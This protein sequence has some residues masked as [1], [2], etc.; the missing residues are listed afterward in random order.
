MNMTLMQHF[1]ELRRRV[2]WCVLIFILTFIVGWQI[3][4]IIQNFLTQPLLNVWDTGS[5]LYSG[6]TDGL[7]IT[8]SLSTLFAIFA[9][10][11]AILWHVW[12]FVSP[13]LK[14]GE[15]KFVTPIV[16]MSPV[17]FLTGAAFAFYILFPVVF[18]FFIELN[19]SSPVP[20]VV[21]PAVKNYLTFSIGLL[22]IFG[23]A[24][25]L[26]LFM[27]LL[28][29]LNVLPKSMVIKS[30]RYAIVVILVAAAVLTPPDIV[31]QL[32]LALPMWLLFEAS[33]FFMKND[34]DIKG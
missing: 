1:S 3:A 16:I 6:L 12:A 27:V 20:S 10:L 4:P 32:M 29:R 2:L 9:T 24:F 26:P 13:G 7:M 14:Y 22:K 28:N 21:L 5:L 19:Q 34:E 11:P 17:L 30:R 18:K 31:S 8:F 23:F 25:Q 15:K 33:I